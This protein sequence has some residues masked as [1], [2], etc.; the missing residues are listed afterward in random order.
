MVIK[1]ILQACVDHSSRLK[2]FMMTIQLFS[3]IVETNITLFLNF[4]QA[5]NAKFGTNDLYIILTSLAA[6]QRLYLNT[7]VKLRYVTYNMQNG[8]INKLSLCY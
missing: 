6:Q 8:V 1:P 3:L 7:F 2:S 4:S 5:I